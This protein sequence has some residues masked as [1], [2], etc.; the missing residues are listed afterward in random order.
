M[1]FI[2]GNSLPSKYS[3]IAPPPVETWLTLLAKLNKFIAATLSPPPTREKA[4]FFVAFTIALATD[5]VPLKIT[6]F[7]NTHWS[8]P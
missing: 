2:P 7:K 5:I 6:H 1:D 4:L 8:I 3:N